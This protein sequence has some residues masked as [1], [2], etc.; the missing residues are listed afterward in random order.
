M[1]VIKIALLICLVLLLS[2]KVWAGDAGEVNTVVL[3]KS[4][5][6]WDGAS[7]PDYPKGKPEITI[8]KVIIPPGSRTKLHKHTVIN[9]GVLIKGELTVVKDNNKTL[10][11]KAGDSIVEVVGVSHYGRNDGNIPAEIIVV[12]AGVEGEPITLKE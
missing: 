12:Y 9:A 6:S 4:D 1:R 5:S 10:Y 3:A 7:L 11:L 2:T 8:L